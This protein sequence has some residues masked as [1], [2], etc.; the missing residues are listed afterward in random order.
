MLNRGE[1][2]GMVEETGESLGSVDIFINNAG[3]QHTEA[4]ETFPPKKW[5]AII[6]INLSAA[7]HGISAVVPQMMERGFGRIINV[8][9]A[10]ALV[11]SP[12]NSAHVAAKHGIAELTKSH[13]HRS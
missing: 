12:F 10:H 6:A 13:R 1:I 3:I 9:S 4:I 8:N 5:D 7:F 2:V 11:G